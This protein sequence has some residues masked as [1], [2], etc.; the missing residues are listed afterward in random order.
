MTEEVA[1]RRGEMKSGNERTR[2]YL[3]HSALSITLTVWRGED[4]EKRGR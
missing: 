4:G 3:L 1:V 2:S